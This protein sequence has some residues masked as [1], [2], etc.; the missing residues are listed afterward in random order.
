M[1]KRSRARD[2]SRMENR[3]DIPFAHWSVKV[4]RIHPVTGEV[5]DV[6]GEIVTVYDDVEQAI[7]NLVLTPKRSVPVNPE[8][9]TDILPYIDRH[10]EEAVPN[11][12]REIWDAIAIWEPRAIV[13][14]IE[15]VQTAFAHFTA[16]IF[17]R[18]VQSLADDARL[19]E[20]E[21]AA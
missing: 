2:G 12:T 9:G 13:D 18:P 4:G 17:W 3:H 15:V 10:E 11:I 21:L 20:V 5:K 1:N 6:H 19:L 8:K 7:A 14:R 16:R